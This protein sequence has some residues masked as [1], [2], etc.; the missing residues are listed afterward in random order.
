MVKWTTITLEFDTLAQKGEI[1]S[2]SVKESIR[3]LGLEF[4]V[5]TEEIKLPKTKSVI[6]IKIR[7]PDDISD[8][9]VT[10]LV[11]SSKGIF[12]SWFVSVSPDPLVIY[13]GGV[14]EADGL[15]LETVLPYSSQNPLQIFC[16]ISCWNYDANQRCNGGARIREGISGNVYQYC[17]PFSSQVPTVWYPVLEWNIMGRI[18]EENYSLVIPKDD[19]IIIKDALGNSTS[20]QRNKDIVIS[21]SPFSIASQAFYITESGHLFMCSCDD[22]LLPQINNRNYD[23]SIASGAW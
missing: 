2:Q 15:Y 23:E 13:G 7:Y 11:E 10:A 3:T 5:K 19:D 14:A 21:P 6:G 22:R 20:V 9:Q 16:S 17:G 4:K 18:E 12:A 1:T 8:S